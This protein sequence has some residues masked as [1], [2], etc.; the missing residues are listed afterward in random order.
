MSTELEMIAISTRNLKGIHNGKVMLGDTG[1]KQ[2]GD[3]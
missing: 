1:I 3:I 2:T